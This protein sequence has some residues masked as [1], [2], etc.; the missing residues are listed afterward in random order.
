MGFAPISPAWSNTATRSSLDDIDSFDC[1]EMRDGRG[2]L[3]A[4]GGFLV[5]ARLSRVVLVVACV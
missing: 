5:K 4:V 3:D 2:S 1:E